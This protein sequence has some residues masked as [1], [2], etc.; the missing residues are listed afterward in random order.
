MSNQKI[1]RGVSK[2]EWLEQALQ[3]LSTGG[4][5]AITV[6]GMAK[7][8]GINKSGFYW[9][10]KNRDDLLH[11]L[12]NY[13][14]HEVTE[15]ITDNSD[16]LNLEPKTRLVKIAEMVIDFELTRYEIAIRQWALQDELAARAAKRV[17]RVRLDFI[18]NALS[19]LGFK[20]NDLDMRAMLFVCYQSLEAPMFPEISC[21]RRR[22]LIRK[23]VDLI[24]RSATRN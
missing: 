8:L 24:T 18:S 15:V 20:G 22:E 3:T 9:H 14:T 17:N 2:A 4:I 5:A 10:F 6:E 13:W 19:E 1:H 23:R 21:K 7:S 12:L 16:L 11:Q